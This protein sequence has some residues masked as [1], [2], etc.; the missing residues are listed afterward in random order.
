VDVDGARVRTSTRGSGRTLLLLTGIGAPLEL[1]IPFERALNP[2]GYRTIT[3]D[4][5]GT[6]ESTAY[7]VPRR[8]P[9]L[10]RMV[11]ETLDALGEDRVDVLGISFGG[12]LAQQLAH[13]APERVRRL[14]L[15]AT[16][17]GVAGLGGVPGSPR[18][19]K[20]MATPR[21]YT[22][23]DYYRR[24]AGTIYGGEARNNPEAHLHGS[25]ARFAHAP[26]TQGY[27][28]QLSAISFWTGVPWLWRLQAP[29]LVMCG[30]DDPITPAANGRILA[31]LIPN[32]RLEI[33]RGGGHLF[34][35][36]RP[37]ETAVLVDD[38]L[39]AE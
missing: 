19:V 22:S 33:I 10:A 32:A 24:V 14:V 29:T 39:A 2:L 38:F 12:I 20:A 21:R 1:S 4:A 25:V 35:L 31:Q 36:E 7:R 11:V 8:M 9:G 16:A 28:A 23:P 3:L 26:S 34:M 17:P 5:P 18:V 27:L 37:D 15:V 30:D 13:Q 6:G